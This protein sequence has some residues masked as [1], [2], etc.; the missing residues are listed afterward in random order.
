MAHVAECEDALR[1]QTKADRVNEI[2][3]QRHLKRLKAISER[4]NI[5]PGPNEAKQTMMLIE[6]MRLRATKRRLSVSQ[7]LLQQFEDAY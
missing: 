2:M 5:M 3:R 4:E 1:I 7:L 6:R